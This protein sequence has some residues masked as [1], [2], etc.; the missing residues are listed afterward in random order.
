MQRVLAGGA[1]P[2]RHVLAY[3][4]DGEREMAA[5]FLETSR[6]EVEQKC[7]ESVEWKQRSRVGTGLELLLVKVQEVARSVSFY[8]I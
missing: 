2:R 3:V 7:V 4:V 8:T 5:V 6:Q 1:I